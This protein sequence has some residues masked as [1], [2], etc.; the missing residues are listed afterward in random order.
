[1]KKI[2]KWAAGLCMA[3]MMASM[4]AMAVWASEMDL[5]KTQP[6]GTTSVEAEVE[7]QAPDLPSYVVSIPAKIDFGTLVQPTTAGTNYK[8][9]EITVECKSVEGLEDKQAIAVL[10]KDKDANSAEDPF[11]LTNNANA[12]LNYEMIMNS[13]DTNIQNTNW[14]ENGFLFTSFTGAD[15]STTHTLRLDLSQLYGKDL[16]EYGGQYTGTLEFYTRVAGV[17]DVN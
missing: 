16:S 7:G 1:M 14:Y 13:D 15:Q 9:E 12:T 6:S 4:P 11:K 5:I 10:V 17:S 2:K 3:A 8:K